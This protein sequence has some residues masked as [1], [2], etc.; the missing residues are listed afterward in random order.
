MRPGGYLC[1]LA[2]QGQNA[3]DYVTDCPAPFL[4]RAGRV[5]GD[6]RL[7]QQRWWRLTGRNVHAADLTA[8]QARYNVLRRRRYSRF[9]GSTRSCPI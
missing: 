6:R 4:H 3:A 8:T 1:P 7:D 5:G 9:P 2:S